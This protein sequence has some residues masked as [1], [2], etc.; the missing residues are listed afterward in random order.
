[1][2]K[3][4]VDINVIR[5]IISAYHR[6][7][8][9]QSRIYGLILGSKKNNIYYITEAIYGFIFEGEEDPKTNKK[10]LIKINDE[11]L[12][13]L[14]NSLQ[15][16]FKMSNNNLTLT[17]SSKEKEIKFQSNDTLII[18][19]GFVTDKE[20]FGDLYRFYTTLEKVNNDMFP[21]INKILLLVNPSH[22]DKANIKYGIKAYEWGIKN[23]KI[24]NLEKSNSFI[25][26][27][28]LESEVFQQLNNLGIIGSIKNQNLWE[29]IFNLKIDKN[30]KKN[31]NELLL[32]LKDE[33]DYVIT[34][35]S[36]IDFIKNKIQES[37]TYMNLFQRFLENIDENNKDVLN[38][39]DYNTI[40]YILSQ[41]DPILNDKEIMDAINN[42][43]NKRYNIDSLTQLIEV[44]LAL[45]DKI[46]ELIK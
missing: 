30:E 42:D 39:D 40:S 38:V 19:G 13:S 33:N 43:I 10:E 24:K 4:F 5:G 25:V 36:N 8:K 28:E 3:V 34:R 21:N 37:I 31:I 41:L 27:K 14:F 11:S 45:S 15:Q 18:L 26:F 35:E 32:D 2:E 20:P 16:K 9:N 44:Q 6:A 7:N 29:K 46:R 12:K 1:M 22:Q 17:K 23:I